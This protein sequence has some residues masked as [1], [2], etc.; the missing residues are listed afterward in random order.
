MKKN[1]KKKFEK[2]KNKFQ[3]KLNDV[4]KNII[5]I[6]IKINIFFII[7]NISVI[8]AIIK[9]NKQPPFFKKRTW[10]Q[11][12]VQKNLFSFNFNSNEN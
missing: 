11:T 4:L 7:L 5:I 3:F 1:L 6:I 2:L 12:I 8:T 9:S 10:V